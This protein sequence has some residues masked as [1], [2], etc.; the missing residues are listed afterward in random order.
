MSLKSSSTLIVVKNPNNEDIKF[1][2]VEPNISKINCEFHSSAKG[3]FFCLDC[4]TLVCKYCYVN[5]HKQHDAHVPN[6]IIKNFLKKLNSSIVDL[7]NEK[8]KILDIINKI[9]EKNKM[10]VDNNNQLSKKLDNLRA[11]TNS[12]INEFYDNML[13]NLYTNIYLGNIGGETNNIASK[14]KNSL[15][16]TKSVIDSYNENITD[17]ESIK[18]SNKNSK[19]FIACEYIKNNINNINNCE[20]KNNSIEAVNQIEGFSNILNKDN[21]FFDKNLISIQNELDKINTK[22]FNSLNTGV[23]LLK[24]L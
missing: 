6:E 12:N 7:E 16:K 1:K 18:K 5:N 13:Y 11:N 9:N 2:S 10:F 17:L 23:S 24:F 8:P 15:N 20:E 4:L 22:L 19:D 14:I 3:D 21:A